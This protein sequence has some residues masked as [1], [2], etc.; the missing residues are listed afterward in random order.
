MPVLKWFAEYKR[1]SGSMCVCICVWLCRGERITY[2]CIAME[3][4]KENPWWGHTFFCTTVLCKQRAQL[5]LNMFHL[6]GSLC[7]HMDDP[8]KRVELHIF[9]LQIN[10]FQFRPMT[11]T[12]YFCSFSISGSNCGN[13][14]LGS[15]S[16]GKLLRPFPTAVQVTAMT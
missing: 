1:K 2:I 12:S 4:G 8:N 15:R 6:S 9:D 10:W 3:E 11:F 5:N 13:W 14:I 16:L 7:V